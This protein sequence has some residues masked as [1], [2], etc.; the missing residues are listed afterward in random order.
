M[1]FVQ[2]VRIK[3]LNSVVLKKRGDRPVSQ[4]EAGKGSNFQR[5]LFIIC[6]KPSNR[7]GVKHALTTS[8]M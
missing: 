7:T 8:N 1:N 2:F 4:Q 6:V 5:G 3:R